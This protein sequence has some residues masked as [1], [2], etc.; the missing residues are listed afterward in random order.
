MCLI[1]TASSSDSLVLCSLQYVKVASAAALGTKIIAIVNPNNGPNAPSET[2]ALYHVCID[3][4][5]TNGV[6]VIGYIHTKVGYPNISGYRD[7]DDTKADVAAWQNNYAVDGIFIDEVTNRWPADFDSEAL[8]TSTYQTL[9]DHVLVDRGYGRAVLNPGNP[10]FEAVID[11]YYGDARVIAVVYESPWNNFVPANTCADLLWSDANGDFGPGPWC[12]CVATSFGYAVSPRRVRAQHVLCVF[13]SQVRPPVGQRGAPQGPDGRRHH[14]AGPERGAGVRDGDGHGRGRRGGRRRA[15]R[16]PRP[17]RQRGLALRAGR[18]L[19][20]P[21]VGR[22]PVGAR[23]GRAGRAGAVHVSVGVG[24]RRPRASSGVGGGARAPS[25]AA[26]VSAARPRSGVS[27]APGGEA[28]TCVR[29][30][31]SPLSVVVGN[32][33]AVQGGVRAHFAFAAVTQQA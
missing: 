25:D 27:D 11:K 22:G 6:E 12:K 30:E 13:A 2:V 9:V 14:R 33:S 19:R 1:L 15:G 7:V 20:G 8:A 23:P 24:A 32:S 10:Y 31:N 28:S 4:L 18:R 29:T 26:C 17:R 5:K 16:R 21:P 3:Y